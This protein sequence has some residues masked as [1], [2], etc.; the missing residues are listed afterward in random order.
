[1][2]QGVGALTIQG[3]A[4]V[5]SSRG[6][7]ASWLKQ[8]KLQ[9]LPHQVNW[10]FNAIN[11]HL[12]GDVRL[13]PWKVVTD[14]GRVEFALLKLQ[15]SGTLDQQADIQL[16]WDGM[17]AGN[18]ATQLLHLA[19]VRSEIRFENNAGIWLSPAY[20]VQLAGV[21]YVSPEQNFTLQQWD[22]QGAIAEQGSETDRRLNIQFNSKVELG[23]I[24]GQQR[25]LHHRQDGTGAESAE[26]LS[27]N[28]ATW[29]CCKASKPLRWGK[30]R[31]WRRCSKL[32]ARDWR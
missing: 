8:A 1:M 6:S 15:A 18:E 13:D 7:L 29:R 2:Q 28:R 10:Q 20:H 30:C 4:Q 27:I 23:R 17:S 3:Q 12:Q 25:E 22:G 31:R 32:P 24:E 9:S 14:E 21:R 26:Y 16:E 11:Q 19:P 5:D